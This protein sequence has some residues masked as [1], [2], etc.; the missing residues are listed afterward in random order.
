MGLIVRPVL[1]APGTLMPAWGKS[2]GGLTPAQIESLVDYLAASGR[3]LEAQRLYRET[4]PLYRNFPDSWTQNRRKWVKGKVAR[5]LGQA[6]QSE[7][8]L[9]AARDGFIQAMET[10]QDHDVGGFR[11]SYGPGKRSGSRFVD[12]TIISKDQRF[13]R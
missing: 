12:L 4:R 1:A 6:D 9:L 2:A 11:V 13:V 3:F 8:L 7:S 5:G 10:L